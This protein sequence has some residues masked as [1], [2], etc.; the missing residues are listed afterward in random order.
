VAK[1]SSRGRD[2]RDLKGIDPAVRPDHS[3]LVQ[4]FV[5]MASMAL[6]AFD[7][8]AGFQI[9]QGNF[10]FGFFAFI[11]AHLYLLAGALTVV[12]C[13]SLRTT[14]PFHRL[15]S[16]WALDPPIGCQRSV[17]DPVWPSEKAW[18]YFLVCGSRFSVNINYAKY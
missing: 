3:A 6:A 15:S 1:H 4:V 5:L 2:A 10:L 14:D 8:F 7:F 13:R 9:F 17:W 18:P 16:F 11:F 12:S